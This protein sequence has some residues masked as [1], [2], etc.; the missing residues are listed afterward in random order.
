MEIQFLEDKLL[1]LVLPFHA[2]TFTVD[3]K[4]GIKKLYTTF[5]RELRLLNK[6][7]MCLHIT[8]II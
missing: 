4:M 2:A 6:L 3:M 7:N 8:L 1:F 5:E